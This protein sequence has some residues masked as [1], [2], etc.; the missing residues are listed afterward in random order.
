VF[1]IAINPFRWK[2]ALF[3]L[4][5]V[6]KDLPLAVVQREDEVR[7]G[8]KAARHEEGQWFAG[9]TQRGRE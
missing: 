2:W 4:C 8:L 5:G 3:V 1:T 9:R 7:N 6:G